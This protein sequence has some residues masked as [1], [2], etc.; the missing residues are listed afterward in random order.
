[1][2]HCAAE[3]E[4]GEKMDR[5]FDEI[6]EVFS[7]INNKEEMGCFLR[8]IFTEKELNDLQLRWE[9][10]KRLKEKNPQRSIAKELKISLCKITRGAKILKNPESVVK[11]ILETRMR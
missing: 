7:G 4:K 8:E 11:R 3:N 9:L 5:L 1:M 10:L 6:S 2:R